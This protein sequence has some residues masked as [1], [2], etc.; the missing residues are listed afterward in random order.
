M[1]RLRS[2]FE[3]DHDSLAERCERRLNPSR[4]CVVF[5]IQHPAHDSLAQTETFC[6]LRITET[7]LPHSQVQRK[8]RGQV[9]WNA[10]GVLASLEP[11]RFGDHV[12]ACNSS[13][14]GFG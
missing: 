7:A 4:L 1:L 10:D 6:Q 9:E 14:E 8:L 2:I 11:R 12:S 3:A 13:R 5:R